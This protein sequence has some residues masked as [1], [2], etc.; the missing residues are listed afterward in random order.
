M[1]Y[2]DMNEFTA[3]PSGKRWAT[4]FTVAKT[5]YAMLFLHKNKEE[6]PEILLKALARLG[7]NPRIL[8]SD[9]AP[10]YKS[11]EVAKYCRERGIE[12]QFS[13]ANQQFQNA[14]AE[15]LVNRMASGVRVQLTNSNLPPNMWA[16]AAI[17]WVDCYNHL[18][19]SALNNKTPWEMEK[20]LKPDVSWFKPFGCLA[21]VYVGDNPKQLWHHKLAPRGL[22]CVY[23]GLGFSRGHKGWICWDSVTK[24]VYCTRNV[25]FDE[26]FFPLRTRDQ[27]MLGHY[28]TTPR[29]R[30]I[31]NQYGSMEEAERNQQALDNL[32]ASRFLE[33][34]DAVPD[35][36]KKDL[37][38]PPC[39][40]KEHCE[41]DG[42]FQDVDDEDT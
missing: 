8:R 1:D 41:A 5:K 10:E 37:K 4:I 30:M 39:G 13:N 18:P 17:N 35:E 2:V 22:P 32:P 38:T 14:P 19:H 16:Y 26:T 28:D 27:R 25:V 12:Q 42:I 20:G 31:I 15:T 3:S 11:K 24:E 36:E 34:L 33:T 7:R 9:G 21:T 6:I 23:L 29:T 40:R